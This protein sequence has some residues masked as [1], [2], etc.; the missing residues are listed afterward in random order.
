M[1]KTIIA[2]M[3][4]LAVM[5]LPVLAA[6]TFSIRGTGGDKISVW[7]NGQQGYGLAEKRVDKTWTR[8][9]MKQVDVDDKGRLRY[10]VTK[11]TVDYSTRPIQVTRTKHYNKVGNFKQ[12][13]GTFTLLGQTWNVR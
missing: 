9:V 8:Y 6:N 10:D 4:V 7:S 13:K 5:S 11:I 1:K 3:M 12:K 2:V